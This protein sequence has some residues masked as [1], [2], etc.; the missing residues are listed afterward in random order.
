MNEIM[1]LQE[2]MTLVQKELE[3]QKYS[4]NSIHTY[5]NIYHSL[6]KF[7]Q[8]NQITTF[9]EKIGIEFIFYRTGCLIEGFYGVT[10]NPKIN[11]V[12]KPLQV[13]LDFIQTGTVKFKMRPKVP[14]FQCPEQFEEEYS[15][16]EEELIYRKYAKATIINHKEKVNKFLQ[17]LEINKIDSSK[18]IQTKHLTLFLSDYKHCK[19]KYISTIIHVLKNYLAFLYDHGF[20]NE[21]I[22][23]SLP[24]VRITRNAFIPYAWKKKDVKK[25]LDAVDRG[26]PKGKRDYAI[27]LLA[28]RLGLRVSDIRGLKLHNLNWSRKTI[29]L[30]MQ[31]TKQPLELPLLDDIGWA[32]IDYLKNGRPETKCDRVFVRHR[33][34]YDSFGENESFYRELHRYMIKAGLETPLDIH[35]GLHSLRSTLAGNLLE[36]RV[37]LPV[38]SEVLGHQS[39][40]TT[41]IYLKIDLNGLR[42]CALDPEEV[43]RS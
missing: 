8:T 4:K 2:S 22:S 1:M 6:Q 5:R 25:L 40:Q 35:C 28:V 12:M 9:N 11:P 10:S 18:L 34:P 13:L 41:S 27:L 29:S 7:M 23:R 20:I 42:K 43:F 17:F 26:D 3:T 38:I 21:D 24:K 36:A 19:P 15:T 31:K 14:A 33:A 32:I 30:T 39:I 16:F 37:P